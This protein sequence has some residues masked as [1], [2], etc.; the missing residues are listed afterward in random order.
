MTTSPRCRRWCGPATRSTRSGP[1]W[2]WCKEEDDFWQHTLDNLAASFGVQGQVVSQETTL[3]DPKM[4]WGHA[5][6]IWH[7]AA[8]RTGWYTVAAPV[9]WARGLVT[10]GQ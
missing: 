8:I 1:A 5:G 4:Q 2:G 3:V 6:N 10:R 9:R 7:N